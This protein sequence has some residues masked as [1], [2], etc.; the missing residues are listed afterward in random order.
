[1]KPAMIMLAG[2]VGLVV[3]FF[4]EFYLAAIVFLLACLILLMILT[5][6]LIRVH[7]RVY[8]LVVSSA[9][10]ESIML[11]EPCLEGTKIYLDQCRPLKFRI[12]ER[13]F[14]LLSMI[15]IAALYAM[16]LVVENHGNPFLAYRQ[17]GESGDYLLSYIL[18]FVGFIPVSIV[19][20]WF[21]ERTRLAWSRITIGSFN[22]YTGGYTFYD[23]LGSRFGGTR[24]PI[25]PKPKDNVCVVFYAPKNPD[26]NTSSTGLLFHQL[27]L[28]DF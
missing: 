2:A 28:Q 23:Q 27:Q 20:S 19:G 8:H 5:G 22:P 24:K 1:M 26:A 6:T 18:A 10:S 21:R 14:F 9:E 3:V 17:P 25:S 13:G 11:Q 15:G 4:A 12:K 16:K 7:S